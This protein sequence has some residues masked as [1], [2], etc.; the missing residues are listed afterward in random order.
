MAALLKPHSTNTRNTADAHK[1]AH[2]VCST[3]LQEALIKGPLFKF[4]GNS[5]H[6]QAAHVS[7]PQRTQLS[8]QRQLT[9][10]Q[11]V[12]LALEIA[13]EGRAVLCVVLP[14]LAR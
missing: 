13:D 2:T 3:H 12:T 10:G 1:Q 8:C 14:A 11:P 9:Q 5:K 7:R 6:A 4:G